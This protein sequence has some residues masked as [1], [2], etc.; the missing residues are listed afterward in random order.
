M[1]KYQMFTV[2]GGGEGLCSCFA[3]EDSER[4]ISLDRYVLNYVWDKI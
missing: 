4:E 1:T 3:F 2:F